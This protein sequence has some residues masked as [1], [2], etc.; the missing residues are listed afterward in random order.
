MGD[1]LQ[2]AM[3][4]GHGKPGGVP[5]WIVR[6]HMD[7]VLQDNFNKCCGPWELSWPVIVKDLREEMVNG[8]RAANEYL[9]QDDPQSTLDENVSFPR[10]R[11]VFTG[12]SEAVANHKCDG[13]GV[14]VI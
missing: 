11:F 9:R 2:N 3:V 14:P 13:V 4:D 7:D 8:L 12:F 5:Y 1:F 6:T 10:Q